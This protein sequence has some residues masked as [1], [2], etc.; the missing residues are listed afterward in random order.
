MI[1]VVD[2]MTPNPITVE[3]DTPLAEAVGLMKSHKC[4]HLLITEHDHLAGI[5]TD[6]DIR[7]AMNSPMVLHDRR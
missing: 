1:T 6:R 4:R 5:I 3:P 7:L 2:I